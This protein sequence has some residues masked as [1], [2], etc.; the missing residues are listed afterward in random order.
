M[1]GPPTAIRDADAKGNIQIYYSYGS[2][3]A[4]LKNKSSLNE[5]ESEVKTLIYRS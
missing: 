5:R 2:A 1:G 3:K 4:L